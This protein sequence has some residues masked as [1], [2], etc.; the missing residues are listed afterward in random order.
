MFLSKEPN[1]AGRTELYPGC[2]HTV[3]GVRGVI[4]VMAVA[5]FCI[6]LVIYR[7]QQQ[8]RIAAEQLLG[9]AGVSVYRGRRYGPPFITVQIIARHPSHPSRQG[10]TPCWVDSLRLLWLY[11]YVATCPMTQQLNIHESLV[12]SAKSPITVLLECNIFLCYSVM[13][14]CIMSKIQYSLASFCLMF[15]LTD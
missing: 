6:H 2:C 1:F 3:Y 14:I 8:L 9:T 15:P 10:R 5:V 13:Y 7:Q 4:S 11:L 12:H